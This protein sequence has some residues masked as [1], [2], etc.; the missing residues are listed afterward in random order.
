MINKTYRAV[1]T[2]PK[3]NLKMVEKAKIDTPRTHIHD[4][5]V[6]WLCTGTSIK[7]GRVKPPHLMKC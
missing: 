5:K 6:A 1:G 2:V 7:N 3:S 4:H